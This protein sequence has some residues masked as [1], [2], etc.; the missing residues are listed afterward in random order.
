VDHTL[1]EM[2]DKPPESIVP[3]DMVDAEATRQAKSLLPTQT[4]PELL[5]PPRNDTAAADD[6]ND[7]EHLRPPGSIKGGDEKGKPT[8]ALDNK[9]LQWLKEFKETLEGMRKAE[10][11]RF[12]A[13]Q[14]EQAKQMEDGLEALNKSMR[15]PIPATKTPG[16]MVEKWLEG[17]HPTVK[18]TTE[19]VQ[20]PS[21]EDVA[22]AIEAAR[23][24]KAR[25]SE[26]MI[27]LRELKRL[28]SSRLVDLNT[29][30]ND[31]EAEYD[32]YAESILKSAQEQGLDISSL[33]SWSD[34]YDATHS[35]VNDARS[36]RS[37]ETY[38]TVESI[39][40]TNLGGW[41]RLGKDSVYD[42]VMTGKSVVVHNAPDG[43]DYLSSKIVPI[44]E[45]LTEDQQN[46]RKSLARAFAK[47]R[48]RQA[49]DVS[50]RPHEM[51]R[52]AK[53]DVS[54]PITLNG[55]AI[56]PASTVTTTV[57][58]TLIASGANSIAASVL[59]LVAAGAVPVGLAAAQTSDSSDAA[60]NDAMVDGPGMDITDDD[61]G[62]SV[63]GSGFGGL[64]DD[65]K[66]E[67]SG[68]SDQGGN[69]AD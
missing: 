7:F 11:D 50:K 24:G 49:F 33:R 46:I 37:D 30:R 40:G 31:I 1:V 20:Q 3:K 36:S 48:I 54:P 34:T 8:I 29:E 38:P 35:T 41:L 64:D 68:F 25:E 60:T 13:E 14:V 62:F 42:N 43:E 10:E 5:K 2:E 53:M 19:G 23:L 58:S 56:D 63:V 45:Y 9:Q 44:D 61:D 26:V 59:P 6:D 47:G 67:T 18:L 16:A 57:P 15:L 69:D 4:L 32:R 66:S 65:T 55:A 21:P 17:M 52:A 22:Q 28:R 51:P 39:T 27:Q 12:K